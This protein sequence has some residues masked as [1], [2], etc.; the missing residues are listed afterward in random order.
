[1][2]N[3]LGF[4]EDEI[5]VLVVHENDEWVVTLSRELPSPR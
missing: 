3:T 2:R 1:M 4:V 5:R